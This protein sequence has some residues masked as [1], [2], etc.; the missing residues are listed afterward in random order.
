M[1]HTDSCIL[2]QLL[3]HYTGSEN[4]SILLSQGRAG[5]RGAKGPG[6][7][8]AETELRVPP[9]RGPRG[10]RQQGAAHGRQPRDLP[11]HQVHLRDLRQGFLDQVTV[12][13]SRQGPHRRSLLYLVSNEVRVGR[14]YRLREKYVY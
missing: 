6:Q 8:A 10:L 2:Q 1:G 12:Q 4:H 3:Y 13:Q 5:W 11:G 9:V 14:S 7:E